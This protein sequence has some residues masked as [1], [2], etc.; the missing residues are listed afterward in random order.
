MMKNLL[1]LFLLVPSIM[2][3][4]KTVS[5]TGFVISG[6]IT[7]VPDGMDIKILNT[8]DNS[9]LVSTNISKGKFTLKGRVD[10]PTLHFL[11]IGTEPPI[12]FYLENSNMSVTGAGHELANLKIFGSKSNSEFQ[13]FKKIFDPLFVEMNTNANQLNTTA[14]GILRD[15][16]MKRYTS[17]LKALQTQIDNFV[18]TNKQSI[19]SPFLLYVTSQI[20]NDPFLLESRFDILDTEVKNSNMG[21]MLMEKI[22]LAKFGSIGSK[23]FDFVQKDTSGKD[24][25]LSSFKGKYVL[26][27]FWASWCGPCRNENPNVVA[28]FQKFKNKNFT[29][30][31]VSLEREGQKEKWLQA[32]YDDNL[33][34]THVS[35]LKFWNN[36]AAVL[37]KVS[38]IPQNYLIDPSGRIVGKNLR[39]ADLENKLCELLG[40]E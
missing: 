31:G 7:D 37:Y 11:S 13:L 8:N 17:T 21:K 27:D 19:I 9:V 23:A 32:I 18:Q 12:Y 39:G 22:E 20:N 24:V 26:L 38:S 28:N 14:P 25:A 16:L 6:M 30:L 34:W 35:D 33:T 10:E 40:C 1:F 15:S 4:Q 3:A 2:I 36:E 29:V 5:D